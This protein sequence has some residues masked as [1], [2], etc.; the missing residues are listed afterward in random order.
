MFQ[1]ETEAEERE[2]LAGFDAFALQPYAFVPTAVL[3]SRAA[4]LGEG[5]KKAH[6]HTPPQRSS[7]GPDHMMFL[8]VLNASEKMGSRC[9]FSSQLDARLSL[10]S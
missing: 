1:A 7:A 5:L 8:S 9:R 2:L 6:L 4:R 3:A 10:L